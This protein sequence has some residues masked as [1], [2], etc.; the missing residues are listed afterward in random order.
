MF[1]LANNGLMVDLWALGV[2]CFDFFLSHLVGLAFEVSF[3]LAIE[4]LPG[5]DY[6]ASLSLDELLMDIFEGGLT[7][8]CDSFDVVLPF[9]RVL[10]PKAPATIKGTLLY[11]S[12]DLPLCVYKI[13]EF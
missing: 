9:Q 7:F 3:S 6:F 12:Y 4:A 13:D 11:L 5:W 10:L 2:D 1:V 8:N